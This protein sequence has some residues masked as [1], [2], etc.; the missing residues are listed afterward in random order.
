[1][2]LINSNHTHFSTFF[3]SSLAAHL[4]HKFDTYIDYIL[5]FPPPP[6]PNQKKL[7][8][9]KILTIYLLLYLFLVK[10]VPWND[11]FIY[12]YIIIIFFLNFAQLI[13]KADDF[14]P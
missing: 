8:K 9:K 10:C 7:K 13:L 3:F 11:L 12:L 1:M 4:C 2:Y 5:G 6:P 14:R